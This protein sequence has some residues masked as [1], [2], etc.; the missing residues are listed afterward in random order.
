MQHANLVHPTAVHPR[1]GEPL[2]A[3]GVLKSGHIIWP[4]LGAAE[5]DEGE[6]GD[7]G[8]EGSEKVF[9]QAELEAKIAERLAR[10]RKK[11]EEKYK[12]Y[13]ALKAAAAKGQT[14]EQQIAE[15][16]KT[17]ETTRLE[18]LRS[19]IQAKYGIS[20]EDAELFLTASDQETLEKQATRLKEQA[21]ERVKSGGRVLSEGTNGRPVVTDEK[22]AVRTLF[23]S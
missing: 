3:I 19:R 21:D 4:V 22:Q 9:T 16:Q 15:L 10:D 12:D 14:A 17:V 5:G 7:K 1:T 8:A 11:T 6:T 20:D 18:A 2:R 13:D 23:G